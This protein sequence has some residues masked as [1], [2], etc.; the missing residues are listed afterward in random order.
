MPRIELENLICDHIVDNHASFRT[1]S[2]NITAEF[3]VS[4]KEELELGMKGVCTSPRSKGGECSRNCE[5][6]II[7]SKL[8]GDSQLDIEPIQPIEALEGES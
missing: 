6:V 4:S 3:P 7:K 2:W 1:T 5:E 8:W